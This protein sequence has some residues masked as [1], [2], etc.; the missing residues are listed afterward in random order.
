LS[1]GDSK[2]FKIIH[3]KTSIFEKLHG[4]EQDYDEV[5][6]EERIKDLLYD[7][8][9]LSLDGKEIY[10]TSVCMYYFEDCGLR[11]IAE[12][13]NLSESRISQILNN[14][15]KIMGEYARRYKRFAPLLEEGRI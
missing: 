8:A 11:E 10:R 7:L 3:P 12:K 4:K 2:T 14:A 9:Y 1:R 6:Y 5:I 13:F 15:R